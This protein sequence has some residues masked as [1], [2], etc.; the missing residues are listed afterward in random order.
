MLHMS[1]LSNRRSYDEVRQTVEVVCP[2][3][4]I[5][6]GTPIEPYEMLPEYQDLVQEYPNFAGWISIYGHNMRHDQY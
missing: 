6:V 5:E 1:E 2:Q 3:N 4:I